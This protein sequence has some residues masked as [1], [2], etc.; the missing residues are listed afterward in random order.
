MLYREIIAVCS[1]IHTN[2]LNTLC[3]HNVEFLDV[4][5]SGTY[6]NRWALEGSGPAE[7]VFIWFVIF[8][9]SEMLHYVFRPVFT[10]VSEN[11][12]VLEDRAVQEVWLTA[13]WR[14]YDLPKF[15]KLLTQRRSVT[16]QKTRIFKDL[17]VT[18]CPVRHTH[19]CL[20]NPPMRVSVHSTDL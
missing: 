13:R 16:S 11:R 18:G 8:R 14:H 4:K 7:W 2:H 12:N 17:F 19:C 1:Q 9:Y 15:W 3:G 10:D 5:P 20:F 6:S